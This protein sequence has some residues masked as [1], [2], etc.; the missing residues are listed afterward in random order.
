MKKKKGLFCG[1]IYKTLALLCGNC[2]TSSRF[3][4]NS[5]PMEKKNTLVLPNCPELFTH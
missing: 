4:I 3:P 5:K 1:H 2:S